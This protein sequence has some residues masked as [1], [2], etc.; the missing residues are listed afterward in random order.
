MIILVLC[1]IVSIISF[2]IGRNV[3]SDGIEISC[4][5]LFICSLI[6]FLS[7]SVFALFA[8]SS[9]LKQKELS[10]YEMTYKVIM[11]SINNDEIATSLLAE[12]IIEYNNS[13]IEGRMAMDNKVMSF[14][15]YDFYYDLPLI[16][17]EKG[18]N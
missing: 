15:H 7:F 5:F 13:I 6:T 10:K 2:I 9:Y 17:I 14:Y 8:H 12:D 11:S 1:L 3:D 18:E 16:E 4:G